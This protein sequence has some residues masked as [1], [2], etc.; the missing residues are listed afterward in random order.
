MLS[1]GKPIAAGACLEDQSLSCQAALTTIWS[2]MMRHCPSGHAPL[3][4]DMLAGLSALEFE[5]ALWQHHGWRGPGEYLKSY[6]LDVL[7]HHMGYGTVQLES[8]PIFATNAKF[9]G[10]FHY[11]ELHED[12]YWAHMLPNC[13]LPILCTRESF[14]SSDPPPPTCPC[15]FGLG[16]LP[17]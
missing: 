9:T 5:I 12:S 16:T 11:E 14:T 13:M 10:S 2:T 15:I 17:H 7:N 4:R 3:Q 8:E 6:A 1:K